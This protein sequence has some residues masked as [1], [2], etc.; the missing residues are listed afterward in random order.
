MIILAELYY[1]LGRAQWGYKIY[2][3]NVLNIDP[4]DSPHEFEVLFSKGPQEPA[5][6]TF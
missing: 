2:Y 6:L 4:N 3:D 5:E 1:V